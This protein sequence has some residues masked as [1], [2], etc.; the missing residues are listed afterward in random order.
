MPDTF[1][2][3]LKC[4]DRIGIVAAV[5]NFLAEHGG[6]ITEA[7][8]HSDAR[9]GVFF[10]RQE[11]RADTVPS[12]LARFAEQFSEIANRFDM[13]WKITDQRS[14]KRVC[15]LV[16]KIDHCLSDIIYRWRNGEYHIEISSVIS[17]HPDCAELAAMHGLA[18]HHVPIKKENKSEAFG[19]I[20]KLLADQNPEVIVLARFMQIMPPDLCAQYKQQIINIHHGFLPSFAGAKPYHA[21]YDH[22]VKLIG[23]TCHYV[24]EELDAGPIIEQDVI[25]VDHADSATDMVALGRDVERMVLSRGLRDHL[26]DRVIVHGNKT[27]VFS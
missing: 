6:W 8:H 20:G 17:N 2:L 14:P 25:R 4:P 27:V 3:T 19:E 21:A 23:A 13:E 18:Y 12:D 16:S 5:S 15:L 10:M 1:V 22:G 11:I 9:D 7:H 24:T 26:E